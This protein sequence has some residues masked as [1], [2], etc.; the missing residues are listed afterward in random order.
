MS[1][2]VNMKYVFSNNGI[3][4]FA[5]FDLIIHGQDKNW[6]KFLKIVSGII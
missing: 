2:I 5:K 3:D 1:A 4:F 6:N